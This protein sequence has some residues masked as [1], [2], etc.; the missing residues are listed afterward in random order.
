MPRPFH[1]IYRSLVFTK[2]VNSNFCAFWLAPVTRMSLAIL[3]KKRLIVG[4]L[5][6]FMIFLW[7]FLKAIAESVN[8]RKAY[9]RTPDRK[10][11]AEKNVGGRGEKGTNPP[12][13][14]FLSYAFSPLRSI[15]RHSPLSEHL[16]QA[17]A[18]SNAAIHK[19]IFFIPLNNEHKLIIYWL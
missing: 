2:S 1:K 4:Y 13:Y 18:R 19:E 16:K 3:K 14:K 17:S 9:S 10:K 5:E 7:F 6:T 11:A 15:L 12:L 8:A